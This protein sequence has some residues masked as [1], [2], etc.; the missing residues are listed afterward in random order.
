[1]RREKRRQ[2]SGHLSEDLRL[3]RHELVLLRGLLPH[4]LHHRLLLQ[5]HQLLGL[6]RGRL[7]R[8]H[9]INM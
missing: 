4:L 5:L 2:S 3:L 1:M 9:L 6:Q 7:L 8:H